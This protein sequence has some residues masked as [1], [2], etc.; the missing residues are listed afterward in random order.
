MHNI[1]IYMRLCITGTIIIGTTACGSITELGLDATSDPE[2]PVSQEEALMAA[3][4]DLESDL[5]AKINT[6][7]NANGLPSLVRDPGLDRIMLWYGADMVRNHRIG[8]LDSNDRYPGDRGTHYSGNATIRCSEITA[9]WSGASA[10]SHYQAYKNS[11][12][13]HR[14]YM[15]MG[16]YNLGPTTHVGIVVLYGSGPA[17]SPYDGRSGTYSGLMFCDQSADALTIDPFS[18]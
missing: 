10:E 4:V 3:Q 7:R 14:A 16:G 17:G 15:E 18:S 2:N 11:E 5:L 12:G 13:H 6:E 1:Y 8:H 9:W